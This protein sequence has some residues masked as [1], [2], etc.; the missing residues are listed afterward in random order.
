MSGFN[1]LNRMNVSQIDLLS[2]PAVKHKWFSQFM[3][4]KDRWEVFSGTWELKSSDRLIYLKE[5]EV[6]TGENIAVI[7]S[8]EWNNLTLQVRFSILTDS[9]KPPEGGVII[10]V[11][12]R[13]IRNYYSYHFCLFKK[14]VELIKR[15]RG[16]WSTLAEQDYDFE[17]G[18]DYRVSIDA[19]SGIHRFQINGTNRME[20]HDGDI[21]KGFV[22]IGI[23]YCDA[24]F[25]EVSVEPR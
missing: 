1:R 8:P 10:Y 17:S 22:G 14:K 4:R 13:N 25:R 5:P 18:K 7:G 20:I 11:L 3:I 6:E 15:F 2:S 23:K 16:V 24:E 12:F 21:L 9:I 19:D